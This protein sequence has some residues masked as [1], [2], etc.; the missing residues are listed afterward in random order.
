MV[1]AGAAISERGGVDTENETAKFKLILIVAIA[2][3]VSTFF[4]YKELQYAMGG[5]TTDGIIER[6]GEARG[7]RGRTVAMVYYR[8]R[9]E[10]GTIRKDSA[11][12]SRG[13]NGGEGDKVRIEY[14]DDESR[15]AGDRNTG[16]LVIFFGSLAALVVG[17]FLFF[18]HVREATRPSKPYTVPKRF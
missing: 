18:R 7:R 14:L 9:D 11:R 4:A 17:G 15:L 1:I 16:A 2:F 6:L 10:A 5:K 8:F 13:F 12:I 3:I